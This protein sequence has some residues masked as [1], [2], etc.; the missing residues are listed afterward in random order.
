MKSILCICSVVALLATAASMAQADGPFR[1]A[2]VFIN[3]LPGAEIVRDESVLNPGG[4]GDQTCQE[5]LLCTSW[6][7][8]DESEIGPLRLKKGPVLITFLAAYDCN[9]CLDQTFFPFVQIRVQ[10]SKNDGPFEV[11]DFSGFGRESF[12][13]NSGSHMALQRAF[14]LGRGKHTLRIQHRFTI[15]SAD[16]LTADGN[17]QLLAGS[18]RADVL[19]ELTGKD[20]E[21]SNDDD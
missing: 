16:D 2:R 12:I 4:N 14:S 11:V 13:N 3:E 15:S 7:T 8:I 5:D 10:A 6:Q 21:G 1:I 17:V 18:V 19:R 20:G 9:D